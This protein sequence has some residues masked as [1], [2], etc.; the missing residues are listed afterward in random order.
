VEVSDVL[1]A[2]IDFCTAL[3]EMNNG[4]REEAREKCR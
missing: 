3:K 2:T 1:I 4:I